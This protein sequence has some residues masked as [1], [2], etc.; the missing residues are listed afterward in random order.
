MTAGGGTATLDLVSEDTV[1][2]Y[3]ELRRLTAEGAGSRPRLG[4]AILVR[5]GLAAWIATCAT[6]RVSLGPSPDPR[7]G[8]ARR[9]ADD[10]HAEVVHVLAAMALHRYDRRDLP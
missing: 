4:L 1:A 8:T 5:E 2:R 10:A 9:L 6:P 7:D 3:E